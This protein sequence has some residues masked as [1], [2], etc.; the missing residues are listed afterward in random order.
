MN[1][2]E[3]LQLNKITPLLERKKGHFVVDD[4]NGVA[5]LV[6]SNFKKNKGSYLL[7]T[8]NVLDATPLVVRVE[9]TLMEEVFITIKTDKGT[10][11]YFIDL[12]IIPL[13]CHGLRYKI[14]EEL[15]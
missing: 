11:K 7:V 13:I 12:T 6:A 9:R 5:L 2:F 15:M 10:H 1:L 14:N 3:K 8:S 4:N